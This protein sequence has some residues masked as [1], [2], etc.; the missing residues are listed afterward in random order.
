MVALL[1]ARF[2]ANRVLVVLL[3]VFAGAV[4][5]LLAAAAVQVPTSKAFAAS[6]PR[7][8][9]PVKPGNEARITI[10]N[11]DTNPIQV[12]IDGVVFTPRLPSGAK[13]DVVV[14]PRRYVLEV[15]PVGSPATSSRQS[16]LAVEVLAHELISFDATSS[17]IGLRDRAIEKR[18]PAGRVV[19][20]KSTGFR[21]PRAVSGFSV[22]VAIAGMG[23][24]TALVLA[25][26]II[27]RARVRDDRASARM[28]QIA[29]QTL[30]SLPALSMDVAARTRR[31]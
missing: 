30:S 27:E 7:A 13:L 23:A 12:F 28:Q 16:A 18:L 6:S 29:S 26:L 10:A 17:A 20:M 5:L 24:G 31:P 15:R 21:V 4:V 25:Q 19:A 1:S 22:L 14:E 2:R 9:K 8:A 3:R 11:S